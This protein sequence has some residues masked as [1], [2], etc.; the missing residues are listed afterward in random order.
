MDLE[1]GVVAWKKIKAVYPRVGI[2]QRLG[3]G[4]GARS[5]KSLICE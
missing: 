4:K 3:E 2:T 1:R 5:G